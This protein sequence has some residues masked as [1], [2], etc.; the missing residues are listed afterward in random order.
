MAP[1]RRRSGGARLGGWGGRESRR[2]RHLSMPRL[3]H[4]R[5]Q[6][7]RGTLPC[8]PQNERAHLRER[9]PS[10]RLSRSSPRPELDPDCLRSHNVIADGRVTCAR[11]R[12]PGG[13]APPALRQSLPIDCMDVVQRAPGHRNVGAAGRGGADGGAARG[14]AF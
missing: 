6:H 2:M 4:V 10:E 9:R 3:V 12:V 8:K 1:A 14:A 7:A 5:M 11:A 13:G